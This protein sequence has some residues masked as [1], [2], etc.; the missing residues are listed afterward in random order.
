[1]RFLFANKQMKG[2]RHDISQAIVVLCAAEA[3]TVSSPDSEA[4]GVM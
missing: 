1:M 4:K 2:P 3:T